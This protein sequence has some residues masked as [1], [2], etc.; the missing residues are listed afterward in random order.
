MG[1]VFEVYMGICS[2][3]VDVEILVRCMFGVGLL[4]YYFSWFISFRFRK[5]FCLN[6]FNSWEYNCIFGYFESRI[7]KRKMCYSFFFNYVY[8][9]FGDFLNNLVFVSCFGF[10]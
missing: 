1:I 2:Y 5:F 6:F 7:I 3:N 10:Y 4:L 8:Y 9:L